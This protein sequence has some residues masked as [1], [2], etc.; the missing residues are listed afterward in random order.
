MNNAKKTYQSPETEV[1]FFGE[2]IITCSGMYE[3]EILPDVMSDFKN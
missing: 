1:I 3:T 2:D